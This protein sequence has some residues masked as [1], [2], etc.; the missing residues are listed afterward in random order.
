MKTKRKNRKIPVLLGIF[1]LAVVCGIFRL[2]YVDTFIQA[3][4]RSLA[5]KD[6]Q[7]IIKVIG[8]HASSSVARSFIYWLKLSGD[9]MH[10][11]VPI[12]GESAY[13]TMGMK[14]FA[15]CDGEWAVSCYKGVMM[16]AIQRLGY[17]PTVIYDATISCLQYSLLEER[18]SLCAQAAGYTI[19]WVNLYW[20]IESLQ[21][22]DRVFSEPFF[23]YNCWVGVSHENV[24]RA[25]DSLHGLYEVPWTAE[26]MH[27]PCD[28]IPLEYQP[29]CISEQ[30]KVIRAREFGGDT[31]KSIDY[32]RYFTY[33]ETHKACMSALDVEN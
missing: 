10:D 14:G 32:C 4:F 31:Q 17:S 19:L 20:Y 2:V 16:G 6:Q 26:N 24:H 1:I 13:R 27:Y 18:K 15:V 30:V 8:E 25:G 23:Q 22:C 7:K 11:I 28:S 33:Q 5:L 29:A 9:T 3:H 21:F 12:L